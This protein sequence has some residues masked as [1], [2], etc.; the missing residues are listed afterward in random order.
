MPMNISKLLICC[1]AFGCLT[2]NPSIAQQTPPGPCDVPVVVTRFVPSSGSVEL[3]KDLRPGDFTAH[4]G[5]V[6][7]T[8]TGASIDSGPKRIALILDASS[9]IH[10]DEWK[11]ETAMA[12]QFLRQARPRDTFYL[13]FVGTDNPTGPPLT[14]S[15]AEGKIRQAAS[16]RPPTTLSGERVYDTL[17]AAASRLSPPKFGDVLFLFGHPDDS[18]SEADP[19]QVMSLILKNGLRFYGISFSDPLAGKLPPGFNLNHPLPAGLG[20]PQLAKMTAATGYP[21]SFHSIASLNMPGQIRL[22]EGFLSDLYAGVAEPYRLSIP[23]T[24]SSGEIRLSISVTN[25]KE[26]SI[27]E[28]DVHFPHFTYPCPAQEKSLPYA[29]H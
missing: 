6:T 28:R 9:S 10:E 5:T 26:R 20:P 13:F 12:A 11:L 3:V 29:V 16:T 15:E 24:N 27:N 14:P 25:Q 1:F 18:G 2:R 19:E 22:F 7:A 21:F 17:S 8:I 4:L 23:I